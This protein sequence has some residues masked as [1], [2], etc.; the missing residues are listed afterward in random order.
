M[1]RKWQDKF[2]LDSTY[3][4]LLEI[5]V[6]S[7]HT[8]GAKAVCRVLRQRGENYAVTLECMC[9]KLCIYRSF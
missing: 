1:L 6:K 4:C 5:L 8:E 9:I 3:K 7:Q 2:G